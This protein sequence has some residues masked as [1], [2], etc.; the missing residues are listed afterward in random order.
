MLDKFHLAMERTIKNVLSV[1]NSKFAKKSDVKD[2][3]AKVRTGTV[4]DLKP[5]CKTITTELAAES[6]ANLTKTKESTANAALSE[7]NAKSAEAN[8]LISEGNAKTAELNSK[9]HEQAAKTSENNAKSS[10]QVASAAAND[11]QASATNAKTS[12]TNASLSESKALHNMEMA[13]KWAIAEASPD[14]SFDE[15]SADGLAQSSKTWA[16]RAKEQALTVTTNTQKMSEYAQSIQDTLKK[17]QD[18]QATTLQLQES[19]TEITKQTQQTLAEFKTIRDTLSNAV[20]YKGAV[21]SYSDLPAESHIGDMYNVKT[22]DKKHSINAGD[23]V[24]WSGS[25]WDNMGGF[26]DTD[27]FLKGGKDVVFGAVKANTVTATTFSGDLDG[28]AT[29]AGIADSAN[30][31]DWEKIQNKPASMPANGGLADRALKADICMGNAASA[32]AVAWSNVTEKPTVFPPSS[33]THAWEQITDAPATATRWPSWSEVTGKPSSMP[34]NGGTASISN[35][36]MGTYSGNGGQQKPNYYGRNRVGFLMSNQS[37]NGDGN[38]KNWLYMDNYDG[39]DVGGTSAIGVSRVAARAFIMS[40]DQNRS[41]WNW[42]AELLSTANY[43][44]YAP[45]KTGGGAS[46]TWGINISGN[47]ATATRINNDSTNMKFHWNGQGGQPTWLWGGNNAGDMYVY[48]PSNFNVNYARFAG[49]ATNATN[50]TNADKLA[51][52]HLSEIYSYIGGRKQPTLT[53]IL[54]RT[55]DY[56]DNTTCTH[57]ADSREGMKGLGYWSESNAIELKQS[58]LNFDAILVCASAGGYYCYRFDLWETWRLK[59]AFENSYYFGLL[60]DQSHGYWLWGKHTIDN[61][62]P[63]PTETIW[64]RHSSYYNLS[65][66]YGVNY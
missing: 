19:L 63:I 42:S 4:A 48:N 59:F 6:I 64:Y 31:I 17:A 44:S 22:A 55:F 43:N 54:K 25:D 62:H 10:E 28:K 14:E 16:K 12:E 37:I 56:R 32:S 2:L 57:I 5:Y 8:A 36:V 24:V 26:I 39:D 15:E 49:S 58:Y 40:S 13:Q 61:N 27:D 35:Q 41:A 45:T 34:A 66:I 46:G 21:E 23:N 38:Y 7:Q 20:N 29:S 1:V 50:A 65:E 11:A 53:P 60:P 9:S 52:K 3:A 47:S 18:L 33:H 51:G 30:A